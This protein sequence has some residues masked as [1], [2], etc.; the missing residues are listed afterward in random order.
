[1]RQKFRNFAA[2]VAS[3]EGAAAARERGM[4]DR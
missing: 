3:A 1:M 2:I 4:R